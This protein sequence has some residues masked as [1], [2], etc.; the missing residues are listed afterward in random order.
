MRMR[1]KFTEPSGS[2]H[3]FSVEFDPSTLSWADFRGAVLGPIVGWLVGTA[4]VRRNCC[5][6]RFRLDVVPEGA[7]ILVCCPV[8][9]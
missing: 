3:F 1:G 4:G 7:D 6:V 5:P 2:I 9:P 8:V